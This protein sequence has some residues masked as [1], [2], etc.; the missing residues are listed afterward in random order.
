MSLATYRNPRF[1]GLSCFSCARAHEPAQLQTV[2]DACGLPLAVD[3]ALSPTAR[4]DFRA[5]VSS[6]WRYAEVLPIARDGAVT[7]EEGWTPLVQAGERLWI[8]DESRNPTGSFKARG[9]A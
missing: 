7:L 1:T 3:Y 8:K 9:L 5:R 4:P 2:C 6:L